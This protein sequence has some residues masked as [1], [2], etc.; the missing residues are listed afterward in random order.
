MQGWLVFFIFI[1]LFGLNSYGQT[2]EI[3][4][5]QYQNN[6]E[7]SLANLQW[8]NSN[9]ITLSNDTIKSHF[10]KT[11]KTNSYSSGIEIEVPSDLKRKNFSITVKGLIRVTDLNAN[12]QLVISIS[13]SDSAIFWKG[14]HLPDTL[15]KINKWNKFSVSC[16]IPRN[17]PKDSN[18]K[19]FLWN[20]DGKSE[21]CIDNLDIIFKE[22]EFPSSL[23]E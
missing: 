23:P 16:L 18:I 17:I 1:V 3:I 15:G 9:T 10:S 20:A 12:N 5:H 22:F 8:M 11:D 6:F 2:K 7:D 14:E 21:T 19:I 13:R 4:V